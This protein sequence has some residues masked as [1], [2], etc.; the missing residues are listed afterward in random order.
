[1]VR[2]CRKALVESYVGAVALGWIFAQGIL[3]FVYML[4]G[5]VSGWLT[6]RE[7]RT[8]AERSGA[9]ATFYFSDF[10]PELIR[11]VALQLI[12]Y[13]LLR[14]LYYK[15]VEQRTPESPPFEP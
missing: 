14:R 6:R 2:R 7:Y 13:F 5:P 12:G 4:S 11:S 15:P 3:H 1:M 8:W 10:V 9:S